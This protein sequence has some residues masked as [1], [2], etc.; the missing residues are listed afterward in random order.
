MSSLEAHICFVSDQPL[1]NILPVLHE[2]IKPEKVYLLCSEQQAKKGNDE[3]Q[4][5]VLESKEIRVEVE[6]VSVADAFDIEGIQ[7][8]IARLV[9]KHEPNEIAFNATGGTK[10]MSIAA[11]EQC[12][13]RGVS[14]F[15]VQTP[16]IVWLST[17]DEENKE[18]LVIAG[19][20]PL[21]CFL[22]AHGV[23]LISSDDTD[24]ADSLL[25]LAKTWAS[26]AE[27]YASAHNALNYYAGQAKDN[28]LKIEVPMQGRAKYMTELLEEI[29]HN[30]LIQFDKAQSN[31]YQD[32][33]A[34]QSEDMRQFI[35]GGWLEMLVFDELQSLRENHP[36]ITDIARNVHVRQRPGSTRSPVENE[37]D[38]VAVINH[39][40]R[41][42]ECKTRRRQGPDKDRRG[43]E[44]M[45]YKLASTMKNMGG[46]RTKGCVV[47]FNSLRPVEKSRA[48]L[49]DIDVID[50]PNLRN[51]RSRLV[52]T[53]GL[54]R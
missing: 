26:R 32:T 23:N 7:E 38:V 28:G 47:S 39:Q 35:N 15:Y 14:V 43:G 41:V 48:E 49:L 50:G 13:C 8:S 21:G 17:S 25:A 1:P 40:M 16:E 33:Y 9:E 11:F 20:L 37:L 22:E 4:K 24:I 5:R 6:T 29:E 52:T 27:K 34:F 36:Q 12:V 10:P 53:L 3:A 51:L 30:D 45:V 54:K 42:F 44:E 2:D 46:L 31:K 19:S 18:D